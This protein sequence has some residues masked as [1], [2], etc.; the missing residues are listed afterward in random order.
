MLLCLSKA[1]Q[2]KDSSFTADLLLPHPTQ[3]PKEAGAF[4]WYTSKPL[5]LVQ[6]KLVSS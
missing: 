5:H 6:P 4:Y 3:C 2:G 1:L